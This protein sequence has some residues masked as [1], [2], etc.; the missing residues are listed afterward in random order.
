MLKGEDQSRRG[1]PWGPP[2]LPGRSVCIRQLGDGSQVPPPSPPPPSPRSGAGGRGRRRRGGGAPSALRLQLRLCPGVGGRRG[3]P[4]L[5]VRMRRG[6]QRGGGPNSLP[7]CPAQQ[8]SPFLTS[9]ESRWK[10]KIKSKNSTNKN[11]PKPSNRR[12]NVLSFFSCAWDAEMWEVPGP[13][14]LRKEPISSALA[15]ASP[16]LL[17]FEKLL[18]LKIKQVW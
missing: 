17:I 9:W 16:P 18:M 11:S 12:E 7:A 13:R 3:W 2:P 1:A 10:N 5:G 8:D 4:T 14:S 6:L 15:S